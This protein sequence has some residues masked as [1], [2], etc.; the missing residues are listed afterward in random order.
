MKK[1]L[2]LYIYGAIIILEGIFLL[3]SNNYPFQT[4]KLT[5]GYS[6]IL[7][8]L[9]AFIKTLTRQTKQVEFSYHNIHSLSMLVYGIWVLLFAYSVESLIYISA[10]LFMFYTFS[11]IIFCIWIFNIGKEVVA[12]IVII[13]T[14]LGLFVGFGTI[15][16]L[17]YFNENKLQSIVGF[18]ILFIIIGINILLYV[19]IMTT[20][21]LTETSN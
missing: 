2:P 9:L 19:P 5:L 1:H 11:E 7:G 4:I 10:F 21:D 16:I 14:L 20:K 6:L 18:G 8:A 12:K 17:Y 13:R 3:F 15:I